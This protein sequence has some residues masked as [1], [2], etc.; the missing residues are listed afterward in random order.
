MLFIH[1]FCEGPRGYYSKISHTEKDNHVW[2]RSCVFLIIWRKQ[3]FSYVVLTGWYSKCI[4]VKF[5]SLRLSRNKTGNR[6]W[7]VIY[8]LGKANYVPW[9][10]PSLFS[11]MLLVLKKQCL[12]ELVACWHSST[13][14]VYINN[15]IIIAIEGL[16]RKV[17][18][19]PCYFTDNAANYRK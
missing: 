12:I 1:F 5:S 6:C 18:E 7:K 16:T 2:Q 15:K 4:L 10:I 8:F 11:F 14:R 13:I 19:I 3:N 9:F 17:P